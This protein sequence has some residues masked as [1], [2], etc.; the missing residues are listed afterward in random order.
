M[1]Y[2]EGWGSL[3]QELVPLRVLAHLLNSSLSFPDDT[4][5]PS[6]LLAFCPTSPPP[7]PEGK[8][9]QVTPSTSLS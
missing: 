6:S 5:R 3:A 1:N 8:G 4:T 9:T 7:T 2:P